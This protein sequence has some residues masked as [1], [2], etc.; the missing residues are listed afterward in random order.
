MLRGPVDIHPR[1]N[2]HFQ[3]FENY[4]RTLSDRQI[5]AAIFAED[6]LSLFLSG[7]YQ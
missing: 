2:Q 5:F 6:P 3:G 1:F 4:S 7:F